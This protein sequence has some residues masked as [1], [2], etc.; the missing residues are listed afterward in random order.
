MYF[1][2]RYIKVKMC[3]FWGDFREN[4]SYS[5]TFKIKRGIVI[6]VMFSWGN[7]FDE[8]SDE[9]KIRSTRSFQ[10]SYVLNLCKLFGGQSS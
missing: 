2:T 5:I 6:I 1:H 9:M 8:I 4:I 3:L 7:Y 10:I